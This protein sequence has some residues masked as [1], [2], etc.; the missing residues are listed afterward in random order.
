[1]KNQPQQTD[2]QSATSGRNGENTCGCSAACCGTADAATTLVLEWRHYGKEGQTCER[3]SDTGVNLATV[4]A[5]YAQQGINITVQEVL[6][7]YDRILES[8]LVLINGIPLEELLT[9]SEA[10]ETSCDS[11]S[12]LSGQDTSCRTILYDGIVYEEL[13]PELIRAGIQSYFKQLA[14]LKC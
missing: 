14:P 11:C 8:N 2:P 10:G 9:G 13:A 3:C 6:L 1:M 7:P 4:V 5:D 12:C